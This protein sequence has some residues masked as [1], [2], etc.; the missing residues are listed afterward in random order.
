[1]TENKENMTVETKEEVKVEEPRK[2]L[3]ERGK[4]AVKSPKGQKVI[5]AVKTVLAL[6]L[7][8]VAGGKVK[9][10]SLTRDTSCDD[11]LLPESE[12]NDVTVE[13]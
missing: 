3:L 4:D 1:M 8:F 13:D 5:K 7:A 11:D 9:E 6:G 12:G 2:N 10:W